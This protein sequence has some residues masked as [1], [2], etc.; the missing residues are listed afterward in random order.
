[1]S[2]VSFHS[3]FKMIISTSGNFIYVAINKKLIFN[4]KKEKPVLTFKTGFSFM[5]VLVFPAF[6]FFLFQQFRKHELSV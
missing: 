1:M 4:S 5:I 6:V 2:I 3:V